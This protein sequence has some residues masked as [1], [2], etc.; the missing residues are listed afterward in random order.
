MEA[1]DLDEWFDF[2]AESDVIDAIDGLVTGDA[3]NE[4]CGDTEEV[5]IP[6]TEPMGATPTISSAEE[7]K[8]AGTERAETGNNICGRY[9]SMRIRDPIYKLWLPQ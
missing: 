7:P 2:M 8:L 4:S 1:D 3:I 9:E 6:V 5:A